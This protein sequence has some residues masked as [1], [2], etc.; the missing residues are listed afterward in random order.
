MHIIIDVMTFVY[1]H[2]KQIHWSRC[3]I[4]FDMAG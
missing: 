3:S 4:S 1:I 2:K